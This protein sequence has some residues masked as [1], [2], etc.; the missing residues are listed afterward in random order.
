MGIVRKKPQP[1]LTSIH[2]AADIWSSPN[3]YL[4]LVICAHYIDDQ[5][6]RKKALLALRMVTGHRNDSG[7]S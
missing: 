1:A 5:E 7:Q 6:E 2:L 4:L 3:N